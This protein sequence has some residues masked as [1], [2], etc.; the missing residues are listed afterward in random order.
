M[1]N[2]WN[3]NCE[4]VKAVSWSDDEDDGAPTNSYGNTPEPAEDETD[5]SEEAHRK[6]CHDKRF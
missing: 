2:G 3:A 4:E 6:F 1:R 5:D